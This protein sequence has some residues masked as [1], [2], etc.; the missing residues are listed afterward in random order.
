LSKWGNLNAKARRRRRGQFIRQNVERK[1][2]GMEK[3]A[4]IPDYFGHFVDKQAIT[5]KI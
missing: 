2:D 4:M 1:K 3:D 5:G